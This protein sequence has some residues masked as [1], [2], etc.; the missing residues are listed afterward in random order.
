MS[1]PSEIPAEDHGIPSSPRI[2]LIFA[3]SLLG[4]R[5]IRSSRTTGS[6][7]CVSPKNCNTMPLPPSRPI[8]Q[9]LK[10]STKK[11]ACS[12]ASVG[13][14]STVH[15]SP[16]SAVCK[17]TPRFPT[18]HASSGLIAT[19]SLRGQLAIDSWVRHVSPPSSVCRI[20]PL[21][22][23]AHPFSASAKEIPWIVRPPIW[24]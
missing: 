19:T 6:S 20:K 10:G 14:T 21:M 3:G 17:I 9:P 18:T 13:N 4:T 2:Q 11:I 22:P 7:G 8:A 23:T 24:N 16:R 5:E 15:V 1:S 12:R